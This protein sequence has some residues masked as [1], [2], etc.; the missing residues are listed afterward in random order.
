MSDPQYGI[1]DIQPE[2]RE[3]EADEKRHARAQI[4][5]PGDVGDFETRAVDAMGTLAAP[6]SLPTKLVREPQLAHYQ[7]AYN[8]YTSPLRSTLRAMGRARDVSLTGAPLTPAQMSPKLAKRFKKLSLEDK[9]DDGAQ[10]EMGSWADAQT[11]MQ[12][13]AKGL[14]TGQTLLRGASQG[15]HRVQAMIEQRRLEARREGMVGQIAKIEHTAE[16]AARIVEVSTEAVLGAAEIDEALD[17][18]IELDESE[19]ESGEADQWSGGQQQL[20][21]GLAAAGAGVSRGKAVAAQLQKYALAGQTFELKDVFIVAQGD[22]GRYLQYERDVAQ[23]SEQIGELQFVEEKLEIAA[24][25]TQLEGFTLDLASRKLDLQADRRNARNAAQQF[26][27]GG[28][29]GKQAVLAMYAAEAF[30]EL[31]IFGT[32]ANDQREQYVDPV[33]GGAARFVESRWEWFEGEN[34]IQQA[35]DLRDNLIGVSQQKQYFD[36]HLPE[37]QATAQQ[38]RR[39]L[40]VRTDKP[41]LGNHSELDDRTD[42]G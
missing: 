28:G 17:A 31:D 23:L 7:T 30:Q 6:L 35:I 32:I 4:R 25:K 41:L 29:G 38:W 26:G 10:H 21:N 9:H 16:V 13:H 19:S 36:E 24:A 15:F 8:T 5:R 3:P 42:A 34:L 2:V 20:G 11:R 33:K 22:A 40:E 27:Q 14:Y 37:W 39:F 1:E 12:V 18:G